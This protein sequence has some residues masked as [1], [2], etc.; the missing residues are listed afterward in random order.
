M[1]SA[2][3]G[4]GLTAYFGML[5]IGQPQKGDVVVVSGA[6]GATGSVAAQIA[7]I[8]GCRVIGIAG[9]VVAFALFFLLGLVL[10]IAR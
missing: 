2:L 6:A 10:L 3:G 1:L 8:K 9:G 4:T 7:K 5:D